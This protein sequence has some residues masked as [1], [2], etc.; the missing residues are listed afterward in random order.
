[1][2]ALLLL[3]TFIVLVLLAVPGSNVAAKGGPVGLSPESGELGTVVELRSESWPPDTEVRLYAAFTTSVAERYPPP[4]EYV[5]PIRTVRSDADGVWET[6]LATD[7]IPG[8]PPSSEPGFLLFRA[9]SD[10]LPLFLDGNTADFVVEHEDRRPTGSGEIRLSLA[11]ATGGSLQTGV[12]GW[13]QA[14]A[15]CFFS[16]FGV[17]SFPFETTIGSLA[18]GEWEIVAMTRAGSEPIGEGTYNLGEASLCFN[19]SCA[20]GTPI[21]QVHTAFRVTVENAQV[22]EANV[23]VGTLRSDES[24]VQLEPGAD[25]LVAGGPPNNGRIALLAGASALLAI[26]IAGTAVLAYRRGAG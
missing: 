19:P 5:G 11:L 9:D 17:I 22:V 25:L 2:R 20:E 26:F 4:S 21:V 18:D 7:D 14:D 1:M 23:V 10:D 3:A 13:H 12:F 24:P 6:H 8:L 15:P 16:P